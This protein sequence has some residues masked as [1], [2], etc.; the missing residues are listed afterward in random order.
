MSTDVTVLLQRWKGGDRSA[1]DELIGRLH[2]DLRRT[3]GAL[4][5]RERRDHTLQPTALVNEAYTRLLGHTRLNLNDR[6]HF[7]AMTAR[8][9]RQ[10]LVD[11]ARKHHALRRQQPVGTGTVSAVRL[12]S[13][14]RTVDLLDLDLAIHAL[15]ALDGRQ[16]RVVEL[17]YFAGLENEEI[18][19]A[20]DI[21]EATV[22][23]EWA[24][25]R[26]WLYRQLTRV[27]PA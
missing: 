11:H 24:T 5:R 8:V 3:A 22:K 16:G 19:A 7:L 9:M 27:V 6:A 2:G 20:L 1:F 21:S 18:A 4:L 12:V 23:R 17:K 26:L 14:G 15:T 13:D 10:V 25:A